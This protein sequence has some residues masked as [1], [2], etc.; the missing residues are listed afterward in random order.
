MTVGTVKWFNAEKGFGFIAPES[1]EDVFVHFSAIQSAG[2]RSLDEG[3]AV[4]FDVTAGPKGAQAANVRLLGAP[5]AT[6]EQPAQQPAGRALVR[7]KD[8]ARGTPGQVSL[9][10]RRSVL[11]LRGLAQG[12][13]RFLDGQRTVVSNELSVTGPRLVVH[14]HEVGWVVLVQVAFVSLIAGWSLTAR[15]RG[16]GAIPR[17]WRRD[18]RRPP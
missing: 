2:Y 12:I 4:E 18:P 13:H 6:A 14:S 9:C 7:L 3:Q 10:A 8:R 15:S 11:D 5:V 1:G 17:T 16:S